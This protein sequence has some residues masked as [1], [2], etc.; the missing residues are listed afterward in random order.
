MSKKQKIILSSSLLV[1][2]ILLVIV[3]MQHLH[4][5]LVHEELFYSEVQDQLVVLDGLIEH[6]KKN[7]WSDP[8]LVT[9]QL[10]DVLNGMDV[11]IS[12]GIYTNWLEE[13]DL[14]VLRRIEIA[15]RE[16]PHDESYAFSTVSPKDQERFEDLRKKLRKAG[17]G[18]RMTLDNDWEMFMARSEELANLLTNPS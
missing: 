8:N 5:N 17:F 18:M 10:G 11:A 14:R 7:N 1:S 15:L 3:I 2:G 12:S 13:D 6:Q 4:L 9:V 16:F